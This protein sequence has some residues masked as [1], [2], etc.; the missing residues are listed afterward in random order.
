[1]K[2]F[3]AI[4][5]L[6]C[7]HYMIHPKCKQFWAFLAIQYTILLTIES[8]SRIPFFILSI[9]EFSGF[10]FFLKYS[11]LFILSLF[12]LTVCNED[13]WEARENIPA[14]RILFFLSVLSLPLNVNRVLQWKHV[15]QKLPSGQTRNKFHIFH[16]KN[17]WNILGNSLIANGLFSLIYVTGLK[18]HQ[19]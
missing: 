17:F 1:M 10:F 6:Y 3:K 2:Y 19:A 16:S 13:L 18:L 9:A 11:I 15:K 4:K 7:K 5:K 12:P 14:G 8:T